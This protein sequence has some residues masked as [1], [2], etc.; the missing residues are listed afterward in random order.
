LRKI[1]AM[2]IEGMVIYELKCGIVL[3]E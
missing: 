1:P 3:L 2:G